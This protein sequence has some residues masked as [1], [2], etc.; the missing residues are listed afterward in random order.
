MWAT[1]H[2]FPYGALH[3]EPG[4]YNQAHLI[5]VTGSKL[6]CGGREALEVE[7]Q[8]G[9]A[10]T[11]G[12]HIPSISGTPTTVN[13]ILFVVYDSHLA[14]YLTL[15]LPKCYTAKVWVDS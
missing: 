2:M 7:A 12:I 8:S 5:L 11:W 3:T 15:A 4:M 13:Y 6:L 9:V 14:A 1:C 10:F